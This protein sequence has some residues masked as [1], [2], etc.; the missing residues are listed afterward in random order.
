MCV[1]YADLF[2]QNLYSMKSLSHCLYKI[3][4]I[5]KF[6]FL[7]FIWKTAVSLW[8]PPLIVSS[9]AKD[10]EN[11]NR[12]KNKNVLSKQTKS[13]ALSDGLLSESNMV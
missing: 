1:R 13:L 8:F 7:I 10:A 11:K 3:F 2:L 9:S 6:N 12:R 4:N 5:Y